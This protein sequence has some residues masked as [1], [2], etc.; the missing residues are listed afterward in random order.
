[1][2]LP[3]GGSWPPQPHDVANKA[4]TVWDAWYTGD[5]DRLAMAYGDSNP[6]ASRPSQFAGGLVGAVA[7]FFWGRP[8]S[9]GQGRGKL[10]LPVA[11]DLCR[12]SAKLL[13]SDPPTFNDPGQNEKLKKRLDKIANT[14]RVRT[15]L[16][17]GAEVGAALGG[18]YM[19]LVWDVD[20]ADHV[21]LDAVDADAAYPEF[22]WGRLV[23]VTFCTELEAPEG[24]K[25]RDKVWRHLERHEPG[26]ILHGLYEGTSEKL[27][28]P[29]P[30]EDHPATDVYA[31]LVDDQQAI[32]TG[33]KGLTSA[34]VPNARPN[35]DWRKKPGLHDL[36]RPDIAG[37]EPI[38][39]F[40]D[41]TW[42]SLARDVR[43][44]KGR[45]IVPSYML[46]NLGV[47]KGSWFDTETEIF[48]PLNAAPSEDGKGQITPQQFDIRVEQHLAAANGA[49][50]EIL[51]EVGYSPITFGM[52]DEVAATATEVNA[53]EKDSLQTRAAK[54]RHWDGALVPLMAT[55]V[56]LDALVFRT[57]VSLSD[58]IDVS[59]PDGAKDPMQVRA[60]TVQYLATAEAASVET[61]VRILHP[62]WDEKQVSDEVTLILGQS[63]LPVPDPTD[64]ETVVPSADAGES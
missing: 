54:I 55:L 15:E 41:E 6:F 27:G 40:I 51:R 45:L 24:G 56:E 64:P 5:V 36:G 43:L 31:S 48:T 37:V 50:R 35:R 39:D 1:M 47:G 17:E 34:Y 33:V 57:G 11:A 62:D 16:L 20:V 12:T 30:L 59:W 3:Q 13:F 52:P 63:G 32:P 38:M 9:P 18:T 29:R 8:S 26:A 28:A 42:T 4:M 46:S 14:P 10:H 49:F 19:R 53:R 7:R 23:A 60:Q 22:R 58:D 25:D 44:A 2:P 21:M 61:K